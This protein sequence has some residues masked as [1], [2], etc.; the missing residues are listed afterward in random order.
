MLMKYS[1]QLPILQQ[2]VFQLRRNGSSYMLLFQLHYIYYFSLIDFIV[3][4]IVDP[5]WMILE[6]S[7]LQIKLFVK[8]I[9]V[10]V[11]L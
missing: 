4:Y 7:A 5:V 9:P 11:H 6:G 2:C 8:R 3:V 1:V 10:K